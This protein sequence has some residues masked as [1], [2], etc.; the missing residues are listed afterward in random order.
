ME[1]CRRISLTGYIGL[2]ASFQFVLVLI[3]VILRLGRLLDFHVVKLFGI[4]DIATFQ[5][6][7]VF[8]VFVSGDNSNPWVFAGGNHCFSRFEISMLFP[9][10]VAAF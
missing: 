5:A 7:H 8:R 9:Q 2:F 4:K 6:L 10:I 3:R 1:A